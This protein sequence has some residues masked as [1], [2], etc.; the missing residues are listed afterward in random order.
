MDGVNDPTDWSWDNLQLMT[1]KENAS[2]IENSYIKLNP[3][4]VRR[5]KGIPNRL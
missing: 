3:D 5:I 1:M 2:K 4:K